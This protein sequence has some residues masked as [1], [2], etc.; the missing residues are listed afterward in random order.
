MLGVLCDVHIDMGIFHNLFPAKRVYA[1]SEQ[2]VSLVPLLRISTD[3]TLSQH[4]ISY[5][6]KS[7]H[8]HMHGLSASN[9]LSPS[10]FSAS[11]AW[12]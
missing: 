11:C 6:H 1:L 10:V 12:A 9:V 8:L 5:F 7:F 2:S 3:Y 4:V